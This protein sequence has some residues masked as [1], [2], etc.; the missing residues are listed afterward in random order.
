VRK[1]A[2]VWRLS[3]VRV[4]RVGEDVWIAGDVLR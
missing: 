1:L 4:R 2:E 3:S